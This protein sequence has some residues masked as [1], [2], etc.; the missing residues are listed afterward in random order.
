MPAGDRTGPMGQGPVTGRRF[1]YCTGYDSPG[2]TKS[3]GGG[4]GRGS[5]FGFGQGAGYGRRMMRGRGW[6]NYQG[7]PRMQPMNKEDEIRLLKSEA[8][9]LKSSQKDIEKRLADLEKE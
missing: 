1:G 5:G 7:Y 9:V 4:M 3:P 6:G 2:F 8:E